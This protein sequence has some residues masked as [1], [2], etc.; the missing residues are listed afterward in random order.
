MKTHS[1]RGTAAQL[2]AYTGDILMQMAGIVQPYMGARKPAYQEHVGAHLR[3]IIEHFG[4]L[5]GA[6]AGAPE[7]V[8]ATPGAT[9]AKCYVVDYDARARNIQIETDP[10][11]ALEH[12]AMLKR[13]FAALGEPAMALPVEVH[14]RGGLQGQHNFV[15]FSSVARELMFLNSHATHHFAIVQGYAHQR[16]ESLGDGFG[17]AP[18]TVAHEQAQKLNL[19]GAPA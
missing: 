11:V 15:T 14:T 6:L 3:H 7:G 9:T 5:A 13:A 2:C 17:K 10:V 18:A 12:I 1:T 19:V 16:G 8:P 4:A